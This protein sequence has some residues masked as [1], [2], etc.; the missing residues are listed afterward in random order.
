[1]R[2]QVRRALYLRA[3]RA[4]PEDITIF[5]ENITKPVLT[6]ETKWV[7]MQIIFDETDG[8]DP[9]DG[10]SRFHRGFLHGHI[11]VPQGSGTAQHDALIA[12]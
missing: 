9:H 5:Y 6:S 10:D 3:Q 1:M 4:L 7:Q 2:E 11:G 8:S 12:G